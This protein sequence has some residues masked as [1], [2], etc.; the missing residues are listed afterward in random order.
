MCPRGCLLF[1]DVL[2]VFIKN[3]NWGLLCSEY[4]KLLYLHC[5]HTCQLIGS[6]KS[7]YWSN[8]KAAPE[9]LHCAEYETGKE[10]RETKPLKY[11][12]GEFHNSVHAKCKKLQRENED[13]VN[14]SLERNENA[15]C[16]LKFSGSDALELSFTLCPLM[17]VAAGFCIFAILRFLMSYS[18][19][20][21]DTEPSN[22]KTYT[23]YS[24]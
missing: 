1:S 24:R 4:R 16:S 6:L 7:F 2:I 3:H 8:I 23:D 20:S 11:F 9:G 19:Y 13:V 12:I 15:Y 22:H 21:K 18:Q 14:E 17:C 5:E 10:K